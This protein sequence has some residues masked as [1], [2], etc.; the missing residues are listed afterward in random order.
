MNTYENPAVL[1]EN[2]IKEH[3]YFIN[4]TNMDAAVSG[5]KEKSPHYQLLNGIWNFKYFE[6]CIDIPE[7]I[8]DKEAAIVDWD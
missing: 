3:A 7:A 4:Y 8:F 6:R 1:Q 2:R 5:K